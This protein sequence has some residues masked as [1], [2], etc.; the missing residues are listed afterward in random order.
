MSCFQHEHV[1]KFQCT[2]HSHLD[3]GIPVEPGMVYR[4][5]VAF[6]TFFHPQTPIRQSLSEQANYI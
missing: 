4:T 3:V 6:R 2:G 1:L 5:G